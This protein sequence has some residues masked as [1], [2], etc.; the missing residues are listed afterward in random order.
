MEPT[1]DEPD[2]GM[3]ASAD[4]AIEAASLRE[5]LTEIESDLL[6]QGG[7]MN[8]DQIVVE[9]SVAGDSLGGKIDALATDVRS[10]SE[11]LEEA[12]SNLTDARRALERVNDAATAADLE[13]DAQAELALAS[14]L[15]TD[16]SRTVL[17]AEVLRRTIAEYGERHRGPLLDRAAELFRLLTEGA[18]S[19]LVPDSDGDRQVLLAKRRGGEPCTAAALSDGTRDQLYLALRLAGIEHQL[20]VISEPPPIVLDDILV[21]FDDPRAAAAMRALGELGRFAQVLLFTH[22]ER[23]VEIA[24]HELDDDAVSVVRLDPRDHDQLPLAS[25]GTRTSDGGRA[26]SRNSERMVAENQI[27]AAARNA[28]GQPLSKSRLLELSGIPE[29]IWSTAIRSLVERGD[30]LKEGEK[31]G[32]RYRPALGR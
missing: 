13:Q 29:S 12:T 14:E 16:Y 3:D 17:A 2:S 24:R 9:S 7:G 23:I 4:R 30:L 11:R 32:A 22:H 5:K 26:N 8:I 18:F 20:G 27:L 6:E 10:H 1:D 25:V 28:G 31:K 21:H 15:A 19:E